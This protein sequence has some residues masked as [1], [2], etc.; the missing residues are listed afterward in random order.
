MEMVIVD[1][2][3]LDFAETGAIGWILSVLATIAVEMEATDLLC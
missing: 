3:D 2:E 1:P